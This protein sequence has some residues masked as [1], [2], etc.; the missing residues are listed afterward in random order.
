M[1]V[2]QLLKTGTGPAIRFWNSLAVLDH[3]RDMV[4][5][6][7][8]PNVFDRIPIDKYE[9]REIAFLD[10]SKTIAQAHDR[11]GIA[12]GRCKH[13]R[14]RIAEPAYEQ[15]ELLCCA[16]MRI[17]REAV[18]AAGKYVSRDNSGTSE[19][20][21]RRIIFKPSWA[22]GDCSS[23]S[24][25]ISL[26]RV[27]PD[28]MMPMRTDEKRR[29]LLLHQV[30]RRLVGKIAVV[31]RVETVS[32]RELDR[33]RVVRVPQE[34][35]AGV[36]GDFAHGGEVCVG[37]LKPVEVLRDDRS[38][39][40]KYELPNRRRVRSVRGRSSEPRRRQW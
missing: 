21:P 12:R 18:V 15:L 8:Q 10:Q 34:V 4:S 19:A 3:D 1:H 40:R 14:R 37:V 22:S 25:S 33:F 31:D 11:P 20:E 26:R 29:L 5:V 32:Q 2:T 35:H 16:C 36:A 27:N 23:A 13:L 30:K 24:G 6:L 9:I 17:V 39:A 7:Q 28:T 38:R